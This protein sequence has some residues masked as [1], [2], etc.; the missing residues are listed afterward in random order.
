[1][2]SCVNH[3]AF[4]LPSLSGG[5]AER[6]ILVLSKEF[7]LMGLRVDLVLAHYSG[8]YLHHIPPGVNIIDLKVRRMFFAASKLGEYLRSEKPDVFLSTID[9]ANII[10]LFACLMSRAKVPWIIRQ[11]SYPSDYSW[12]KSFQES[13]VSFLLPFAYRRSSHI[14][15]ISSG[16]KDR[17][18]SNLGITKTM[19]SVIFNPSFTQEIEDKMNLPIMERLWGKSEQVI[20]S[21]GRLSSVKDF[22][23]LIHAFNLVVKDKPGTR[24][25]I[26]G[27]GK[28]R[29]M[30][31]KL[32]Q[33][34]GLEGCVSMPGFKDNPFA[35]IR[36]AK[37]FVLSSKSE[38]FP[39]VLVEAMACGCPIVSTDC[40]SGPREILN[41]GEF[42]YLVPVGNPR[43][44]ATAIM[45]V[46]D[47]NARPISGEWLE[48]FKPKTIAQQYL[49]VFDRLIEPDPILKE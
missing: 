35:Y 7:V 28:E 29:A 24:L 25:L 4:F 34:L 6:V 44:L 9:M 46:L 1:M 47:G 15:A 14:I 22:S 32:V 26:L 41:D 5:G 39:N 45:D 19:V 48:Q 49:Q 20:I 21:V 2:K 23:S 3:I 18:V 37:V 30:L 8:E 17:I 27:D 31:E 42:G 16:M 11:A 36:Q 38:G 12:E 40:P 13:I 33:E 10:A 43:A